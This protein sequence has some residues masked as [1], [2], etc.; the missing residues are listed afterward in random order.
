MTILGIDFGTKRIGVAV[1]DPFGSM[2]FPVEIVD[3]TRIK[4]AVARIAELVADRG[5]ERVVV[6][7]PVNM[8]GTE[9]HMVEAVNGFVARLVKRLSVD[10]VTWD[11]RLSSWEVEQTLIQADVSRE[12]RKLVRDKLAAQVILQSY[13]DSLPGQENS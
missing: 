12:K 1:S 2:A 11:E 7:L 6:G 4:A 8:N 5:A 9:G 10:V 3:G 13:L